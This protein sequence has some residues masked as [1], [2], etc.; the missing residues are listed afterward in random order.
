MEIRC[1]NCQH[2]GPAEQV[3]PTADGVALICANC[4]HHNALGVSDGDGASA[5]ARSVAAPPATS[6]PSNSSSLWLQRDALE[7]LVPEPGSGPRCRKCA[8]LLADDEQYCSRCGLAREEG[9]RFPPGAAPWERPPVGKED[10]HEQ[11]TLLWKALR[12][13]PT[14]ENLA[15]FADFA[16]N[17]QLLEYGVRQ[18][19]FFMVDHPEVPR[20]RE[21]LEELAA[22]FHARII[23]AQAQAQISAEG[24][25][26]SAMRY[27]QVL[28][29]TVFVVWG[30]IF[31]F[32][33]SK[34]V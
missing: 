15:K 4:G 7:R 25:G 20:A 6:K 16:K 5:G 12:D 26:Q 34:V 17:E 33:L 1:T 30:G 18:L 3:L 11:A 10:V 27:K 29:W 13:H 2:L 9:E 19:R 21:L 32:F 23:V 14:E 8:H 24:F 22:S 31:L 28:L